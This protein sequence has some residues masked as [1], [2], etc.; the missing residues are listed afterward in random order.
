QQDERPCA[1][2]ADADDLARPVDDLESLQQVAA[3]VLQGAPVRVQLVTEH[4]QDLFL[5]NTEG[6]DQVARR[7]D[8]RRLAHDPVAAVYQLGELRQRLQ[9]VASAR[10]LYLSSRALRQPTVFFALR[11]PRKI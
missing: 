10:L 4:F 2:A 9:A 8:D 11:C 7:D 1:H 6:L 3:V 5:G